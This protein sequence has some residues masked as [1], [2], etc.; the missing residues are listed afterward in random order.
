MSKAERK[1]SESEVDAQMRSSYEETPEGRPARRRAEEKMPATSQPFLS[2]PSLYRFEGLPDNG[3]ASSLL[4]C[5]RDGR[6]PHL[7]NCTGKRASKHSN[8][9]AVKPPK[10]S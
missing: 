6:R 7:E 9:S 2:I 3:K 1:L 5:Q 8:L 4:S 10:R